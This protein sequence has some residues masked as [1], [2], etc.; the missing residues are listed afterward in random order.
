MVGGLP[1]GSLRTRGSTCSARERSLMASPDC[2][3]GSI[4]SYDLWAA[5]LR[6][7]GGVE[8][9]S[10][11]PTRAAPPHIYTIRCAIVSLLVARWGQARQNRA[12]G[13]ARHEDDVAPRSGRATTALPTTV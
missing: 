7:P 6:R 8:C 11:W 12:P 13:M 4:G 2:S 9:D 10:S 1:S 5:V 3:A